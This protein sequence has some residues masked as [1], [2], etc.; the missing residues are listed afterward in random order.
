M[1][2]RRHFPAGR[3]PRHAV[4]ARPEGASIVRQLPLAGRKRSLRTGETE[5][6]A[7]EH[8]RATGGHQMEAAA[9]SRSGR[10]ARGLNGAAA[11]GLSSAA[12][13]FSRQYDHE[14]SRPRRERSPY[15]SSSSSRPG[16][17]RDRSPYLP[18]ADKLQ[19]HRRRRRPRPGR[20]RSPYLSRSP[21]GLGY[22]RSPSPLYLSRKRS[23]L[24]LGYARSPSPLY[25]P[26]ARSPLGLGYGRS[27]SP[28]LPRSRSPLWPEPAPRSRRRR[29]P[30]GLGLSPTSRLYYDL[31]ALRYER[32]PPRARSPPLP[33]PPRRRRSR[34]PRYAPPRS[35]PSRPAKERAPRRPPPPLYELKVQSFPEHCSDE[36]VR[37][38]LQHA[39]KKHGPLARV[40]LHGAGPERYALVAYGRAKERDAAVAA[41]Q[42]AELFGAQVEVSACPD[43]PGRSDL[44][45]AFSREASL[46]LY[47]GNLDKETTAAQ[48]SEA[49]RPFGEVL[50]AE[51]KP[52]RHNYGF[53]QFADLLSVSRAFREMEGQRLGRNKVALGFGKNLPTAC[54]WLYGLLGTGLTEK[55]LVRHFR[56]YGTLLR[57]L[58]DTAKGTALLL[59][60]DRYS[61]AVAV[62]KM[63]RA[64]VEGHPLKALYASSRL[65]L[66]FCR[67]MEASGQDVGDFH[68]ELSRKAGDARQ[69]LNEDE[70][71][72]VAE[73]SDEED[74]PMVAEASDEEEVAPV[75]LGEPSDEEDA[76][77]TEDEDTPVDDDEEEDDEDTQE[78]ADPSEDKR[79]QDTD[80]VETDGQ[81]EE[82]PADPEKPPCDGPLK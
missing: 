7:Q 3:K 69:E 72:M 79:V 53:V 27:R 67:A 45:L 52:A 30:L 66:A 12:R 39:F 76:R 38:G 35:R 18:P 82:S 2:S 6:R 78:Q 32:L 33:P 16:R 44:E 26:R 58:H 60:K 9:E 8:P 37:Q 74:T 61:A 11:Y 70:S 25:L 28:F 62:S 43:P 48:L 73:A 57:V 81:Q 51:I 23:P 41:A 20:E 49:F 5:P 42:G 1:A 34:S 56:H 65:Q 68:K 55:A 15:A 64:T 54:V 47:V 13:P 46:T 75:L 19:Q 71:E 22:G 4:S 14:D 40:Q 59:Y 31:E 10:R 80:K 24:G 50:H 36:S 29:S 63:R 17:S 21:L 77:D